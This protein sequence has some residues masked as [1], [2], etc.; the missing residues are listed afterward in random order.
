M[1]ITSFSTPVNVFSSGSPSRM[2]MVRRISLGMTTLP[3]SSACVNQV[4]KIFVKSQKALK[5]LGFSA[6]GT[7]TK[8]SNPTN[9]LCH[10]RTKIDILLQSLSQPFPTGSF[11]CGYEQV[12]V[13]VKSYSKLSS[14]NRSSPLFSFAA[15]NI[16]CVKPLLLNTP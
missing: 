10:F 12:S 8:Q 2:R 13:S 9:R 3:R 14:L 7:I 11:L 16:L 4:Q 1:Y 6:F 5:T 15:S